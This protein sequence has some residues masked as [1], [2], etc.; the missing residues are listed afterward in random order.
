MAETA[1]AGRVVVFDF[2]GTLVS[3]DSFAAFLTAFCLAHPLRIPLVVAAVPFVLV[4]RMRSL[5][6][7]VSLLLWVATFGVPARPFVVAMKS[8]GRGVLPKRIHPNVFGE[9]VA[10]VERGARVVIVTGCHPLIVRAFLRGQ[11]LPG[12]RVLGTRLARRRGGFVAAVHCIGR[13]KVAELR[14]WLGLT[15]FA[16]VYTDSA[17]DL[18]LVARADAV[19]LVN[20][21]RRLTARVNAL[22]GAKPVRVLRSQR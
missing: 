12:V 20:P 18:P 17:L 19:T 6:R 13:N 14:K 3:G 21:N 11:N 9:L 2:D 7:A 10:H 5:T 4:A 1:D 15:S 22:V 16:L 8:Y